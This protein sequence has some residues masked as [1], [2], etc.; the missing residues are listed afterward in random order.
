MQNAAE[1]MERGMD[2]DLVRLSQDL[3]YHDQSHFIKD[4]KSI[5]GSTP[6]DYVHS[7]R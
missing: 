6:E 5:I 7:R 1:L 3:G 2:C 4:F